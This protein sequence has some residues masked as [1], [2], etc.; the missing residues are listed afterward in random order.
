VNSIFLSAYTYVSSIQ[1]ALW[2]AGIAAAAKAIDWFGI[3]LKDTHITDKGHHGRKE[4][5]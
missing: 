5:M 2:P 1:K 4:N 3:K